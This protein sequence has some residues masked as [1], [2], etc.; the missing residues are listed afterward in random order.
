MTSTDVEQLRARY[1]A[2]LDMIERASDRTI[3]ALEAARKMREVGREVMQQGR[4]LVNLER[5]ME[6]QPLRAE[7][8]SALAELERTRHESQR[9]LFQ[10][11]HAEGRTLAEIGRAYGISRQLVSRLVNEPDPEPEPDSIT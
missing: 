1:V 2:T 7:L 8:S 6:P 10:I 4:P 9:L 3:A 11:L 5:V